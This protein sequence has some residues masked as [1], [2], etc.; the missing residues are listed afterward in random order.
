VDPVTSERIAPRWTTTCVDKA[1][2]LAR[3]ARTVTVTDCEPLVDSGT[4]GPTEVVVTIGNALGSLECGDGPGRVDHFE[5]GLGDGPVQSAP[6]DGTV[7]LSD[8]P[9]G[10]TL[11]LPL[12]AYEAGNAQPRWGST[13]QA[14]PGAGAIVTA[15][16]SPLDERG[17]LDVSPAE[18]LAA[19]GLDCDAL[20]E[21]LLE[22]LGEDGNPVPP[23]VAPPRYVE[24]SGCNSPARFS[25][26]LAG[27]A[28]VRAT[29]SDGPTELGR[30][31]CSGD[32]IPGRA[33]TSTCTPEP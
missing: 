22:R 7:T 24:P 30:V 21:L 32:V 25:S 5:V 26:I 14:R 10:S 16:C 2:T 17:A 6:C 33:V 8:V 11:A 23:D 28:T 1:S 15:T 19:L 27:P 18:A 9:P 12:L 31:L 3:N 20:G 29:V 4:L 13:C